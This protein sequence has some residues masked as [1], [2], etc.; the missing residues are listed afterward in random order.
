MPS[1]QGNVYKQPK[2]VVIQQTT[3]PTHKDQALR[4]GP[5]QRTTRFAPLVK[6]GRQD[7]NPY[8]PSYFEHPQNVAMEW[9]KLQSLPKGSQPPDWLDVDKLNE[10]YEYLKFANGN[11]PWTE[12]KYLNPKDDLGRGLLQ[13]M[14]T[15][16]AATMSPQYAAMYSN[17]DSVMGGE[18]NW[19]D[20][21]PDVRK[22]VLADPKFDIAMFPAESRGQI[23][24]DSNFDWSRL[25]AWQKPYYI[26]SSSPLLAGGTQAA[27]IGLATVGPAGVVGGFAVGSGLGWAAGKV[28]YDPVKEFW[29][30]GNIGSGGFGLLQFLGEQPEKLLGFLVQLYGKAVGVPGAGA[31]E[32]ILTWNAW[33]AGASLSETLIPTASGISS[34]F[35]KTPGRLLQG[36][37]LVEAYS[38]MIEAF[39]NPKSTMLGRTEK[40]EIGR[41]DF[42]TAT[43]NARK[44][45]EAGAN[46]REVMYR[47][48]DTVGAQVGDML[49]QAVTDPLNVVPGI[50]KNITAKVL[51]VTGHPTAAAAMS[52]SRGIV[53]GIK[54]YG[55]KVRA[56]AV[57]PNFKYSEMTGLQR[58]LAG[59]TLG[60]DG[61]PVERA[62][63]FTKAPL[64]SA[65]V[66]K[67][68]T[69]G[70]G[71]AR[72]WLDYMTT[73][74]PFARA[75]EGL[76]MVSENMLNI[77]NMFESPE[78][79]HAFWTKLRSGDYSQAREMSAR[80]T[81]APEMYTSLVAIKNYTMDGALTLWKLSR[82]NAT[83]VERIAFVL[84][85]TGQD[86][87]KDISTPAKA[88]QTFE[89]LR[90]AI[91]TLNDPAANILKTEIA[92][93]TFTVDDLIQAGK[94]FNGPSKA[95]LDFRQWKAMTGYEVNTHFENWAKDFFH[96]APD[97]KFFRAAH[98]LKTAQSLLL[99]GINPK[100]AVNNI[101]N[102]MV[103]RVATGNFGYMTPKQ[104]AA[105][106]DDL[107]IMPYRLEEGVG[108]AGEPHQRGESGNII[109]QALR[110]QKGSIAWMD[111]ALRSTADK[112][113]LA[114][115]FSAW[116]EKV[117]G[118]NAFVIGIK[119]MY[120]QLWRV[121][122]G[123][124]RMDRG[125][126]AAINKVY[127][128]GSDLMY[129]AIEAG[130]NKAHIEKIIS[131]SI[132]NGMKEI[133][134][135]G[136]VNSVARSQGIDPAQSATMLDEMG[137]LS[138]LD[139][140]L[141]GVTSEAGISAAFNRAAKKAQD[142]IDI[143]L[144]NEFKTRVE[145]VTNKITH[146]GWAAVHDTYID[147]TMRYHEDWRKGF[148]KLNDA[149]NQ[150][151]MIDD[152]VLRGTLLENTYK[153]LMRDWQRTN[154]FDL[155]SYK[156][157]AEAMGMGKI[158]VALDFLSHKAR[159]ADLWNEAFQFR[160]DESTRHTDKY[161]TD[162]DNPARWDDWDLTQ[163]RIH[164]K[165]EDTFQ[166]V[167]LEEAEMGALFSD[168]FKQR[169]GD[170]IGALAAQYW[171][172]ISDFREKMWT[173]QQN[174]RAKQRILTAEQRKAAAAKF[175]H[176]RYPELITE[177][178]HMKI[179]GSLR[180]DEAL[181]GRVPATQTEMPG[182]PPAK[183][184][185]PEPI[186]PRPAVDPAVYKAAMDTEYP[187]TSA[188]P[189][190]S[191]DPAADAHLLAIV[192]RYGGDVGKNVTSMGEVTPD[193]M[194]KAMLD[195][196]AEKKLQL[197]FPKVEEEP[198]LTP[199]LQNVQDA[200]LDPLPTEKVEF[201]SE[202]ERLLAIRQEELDKHLEV[203][204]SKSIKNIKPEIRDAMIPVLQEMAKEAIGT[205]QSLLQFI[206]KAGGL[207]YEK[208]SKR[209]FI[210]DVTGEPNPKKDWLPGLFG[211]KGHVLD[212]MA[213]MLEE[214]GFLT[215]SDIADPMDNG[216]V[217][218]VTAMIQDELAGKKHFRLFDDTDMVDTTPDW[219]KNIN[220]GKNKRSSIQRMIRQILAGEDR[221]ADG[222]EALAAEKAIKAE[223]FNRAVFANDS[224]LMR[225][226]GLEVKYDYDGWKSRI[227][228]I[229]S[230]VPDASDPVLMRDRIVSEGGLMDEIMEASSDLP[231][232]APEEYSQYYADALN[233]IADMG[234]QATKLANEQAKKGKDTF[235]VAKSAAEAD[236]IEIQAEAHADALMTRDVYKE[237]LIEKFGMSE[238]QA[239]DQVGIIQARAETWAKHTGK[240]ADQFWQEKIGH[241]VRGG[242]DA[243]LYQ[244]G[245]QPINRRMTPE[246]TG[247]YARALV[248][249]GADELRR[250]VQNEASPADR[251]AILDAAHGIDAK[252][253]ETVALQTQSLFQGKKGAISWTDEGRA[254][255]HALE[256][257][258]F[259]TVTHEIGHLFVQELR[260]TAI[261]A[262]P[263][264]KPQ[265]EADLRTLEDWAG[266]KAGED[267]SVDAH[268]KLARGYEQYIAEGKAPTPA[269]VAVFKRMKEWM[270]AIYKAIVG[271]QIDVNLSDD[272][273]RVFDRL[274]GQE[275]EAPVVR[276][277]AKPL[278][279]EAQVFAKMDEIMGVPK[280]EVAT[281]QRYSDNPK[282]K[283]YEML[284]ADAIKQMFDQDVSRAVRNADGWKKSLAE[285]NETPKRPKS[286]RDKAEWNITW[287]EKVSK[288]TEPSE[289]QLSGYRNKYIKSVKENI[290][291][292]AS[293]PEEVIRQRPE[294]RKAMDARARYE[295]GLHTSFANQ[296]AGVDSTMKM[297]MGYKVKRQDG[298]EI[299]ANQIAEIRAQVEDVESVLGTMKDIF[300]NSDI[301]IAHTNGKH[302]FLSKAGGMYHPGDKTITVGIGDIKAFAH[303]WAHWMDHEAGAR[304]R[305]EA[306]VQLSGRNKDTISALSETRP[307]LI[308]MAKRKINDVWEVSKIM[309]ADLSKA[310]PEEKVV[311]ESIKYKLGPYWKE[312]REIWARLVEQ[313][314]GEKGSGIS[315]DKDL[316]NTPGWWKQED[317][318]ALKPMIKEELDRRLAILRGGAEAE[319]NRVVF[320]KNNDVSYI[321][322]KGFSADRQYIYIRKGDDGKW[323][324]YNQHY[325]KT[326]VRGWVEDV[327]VDN[328]PS[329]EAAKIE[330][331]KYLGQ[332]KIV[333]E[334]PPVVAIEIT[335]PVAQEP[336][337]LGE[338]PPL[339]ATPRPITVGDEVHLPAEN[340]NAMVV[341][342][343]PDGRL[344]LDNGRVESSA[345]VDLIAAQE[346]MFG[347][348]GEKAP[349]KAPPTLF[350]EADPR[351][352]SGD[353]DRASQTLFEGE[354]LRDAWST[355]VEPLLSGMEQEA[356]KQFRAPKFDS[357][358]LDAQTQAS[359]TKYL[360]Q[361]KGEMA[362]SKLASVRYGEGMRDF[363]MLNYNRRYGFDKYLDVVAPYQF[364]YTRTM[365]NWGMRA[366]DRPAFFSNYARLNMM[367]NR[368][369]NDLPE[370]FR[371]KYSIHAPWLPDWMGDEIFI[372]P[373][374]SIFPFANMLTPFET[375]ARDNNYQMIETE[376]ILQEWAQDE[377]YS[378]TDIANAAS[379]RTGSIWEKAVAEAKIRRQSDISNPM[380]FMAALLGPAWY[381]SMPAKALGLEIPYINP[382]G[383]G[384][385]T[386]GNLPITSTARAAA[387]VTRGTWAEPFGQ[388]VGLLGKPE[389]WVRKQTGMPEFGEYGDYYVKRQIANMVVDGLISVEQAEQAMLERKGEIYDQARE[390]V[391]MELAMRI[392]GA[393]GTYAALNEGLAAGASAMLPSLLGGQILP[394]GELEYRGQAPE[395]YQ[396]LK[397]ADQLFEDLGGDQ[398]AIDDHIK[399]HPGDDFIT[400]FFNKYPEYE[401]YLAKG[402]DEKTLLRN[403][404]IGQ[405]W[406][407]YMELS[408]EDQRIIKAQMPDIF[409]RSFMDKET[410]SYDSID[411]PTLAMWAKVFKGMVPETV[412]TKEV[413]DTPQYQ[414]P[415]ILGMPAPLQQAMDDY[416]LAK[417]QTFPGINDIQSIYFAVPENRRRKVLQFYPQL[418][419]YW[420]WR[421][422]YLGKHP[423][424]AQFMDDEFNTAILNNEASPVGMDAA[425][426]QR[427]LKYYKSDFIG[428]PVRTYDSYFADVSPT[429]KTQFTGFVLK[430]T[431]MGTGAYKELRLIWEQAG[432][433]MGNMELWI[434]RVLIPTMP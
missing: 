314:V 203:I 132:G 39:L 321:A 75:R 291:H 264:Y 421:R 381:L 399:E 117:E 9:N 1:K 370:R 190:G 289:A 348:I 252:M 429:L 382:Q 315:A 166:A 222:M 237:Q 419:D 397:M 340:V 89:T 17:I 76:K 99:L 143:R 116:S 70:L 251:V 398:Q 95:P 29:Q 211:K 184:V 87:V 415:D 322:Q 134:A 172:E 433:P 317:F 38:P 427:I 298:K 106:I 274:L 57:D 54:T 100:Y 332:K 366:L 150:L 384:A 152:P 137:V 229:V 161:R 153:E 178:E 176:E 305:F 104:I 261:D 126:E 157:M 299:P 240:S 101:I 339:P 10:A 205:K 407:N 425:A 122:K 356:I 2:P 277:P 342:I 219:Y 283:P 186:E 230:R 160:I 170:E 27:A 343:L 125:L 120:N 64:L 262:L 183:P 200:T 90:T 244:E 88:T 323:I 341:E 180:I 369:A 110:E 71:R 85:R 281:L 131:E 142:Q 354:M 82:D 411:T 129:R 26:A 389:E 79:I 300:E 272:V 81:E 103:S 67:E 327:V 74:Q 353:Y 115:K 12:W 51:D 409:K 374:R 53:E 396:A 345:N 173:E 309:K 246:E 410:R 158:P 414:M 393:A 86:I 196:A 123:F 278:A 216:G 347:A 141:K 337:E 6:Q 45:I 52:G 36:Q 181:R 185:T 313:Y 379:T 268:E 193:L 135:K 360:N 265:I 295:K 83:V 359:L 312:P 279:T 215:M 266:V 225:A 376:R 226:L 403:F 234:E 418:A 199:E 377:T 43:I 387:A 66:A 212:Q 28:G 307:D 242:E 124:T 207:Y 311:I 400:N 318:D 128:G 270:L 386:I 350:Q 331:E 175:W 25:P 406:D 192:R 198:T 49:F 324:M 267:W 102:N 404:L 168:Q 177:L 139:A 94:I 287:W 426:A 388:L 330:A 92:A 151:D 346:N 293:V 162:W 77:M 16:P 235:A 19:S 98:M 208:G 432:K 249:A 169:H 165:F 285:M 140:N 206:Q 256:S 288:Q 61:M 378:Q 239:A 109:T 145:H 121:D 78:E 65:Q 380:D 417:R 334:Q 245:L 33:N 253:A 269:L 171:Q 335:E 372:D 430:G 156:G 187:V 107:G 3:G 420:D 282:A 40:W 31:I 424:V 127:P 358:K 326:A 35:W 351:T 223:A 24:A 22:S 91:D 383:G 18:A 355:L 119:R 241:I 148:D 333:V 11:T 284:E 167:A 325:D 179:G 217:N 118:A 130:M 250:A 301:T 367:Q 197:E 202:A 405:I 304:V 338:A 133:Y 247:N 263:E 218:K 13:S 290:S 391:E 56:G 257:P 164:K 72:W 44:E 236:A 96:L 93:G 147:V 155:S 23:M 233:K 32:D 97:S 320:V 232:D 365:L 243:A 5:W 63:K 271:S 194:K 30:Q 195:R 50:S 286:Q 395:W 394:A 154:A 296:S 7:P 310:T 329:L 349:P 191:I 392:P 4:K 188:K 357:S 402:K 375:M 408:K 412:E 163:D 316:T 302:P 46:Y 204:Q 213:I 69:S 62:G 189:D 390:R 42:I 73:L 112:I 15:P 276:E 238:E 385:E 214:E 136:L 431:A 328:I 292:G 422:A 344:R 138:E 336:L 303:E 306:N 308:Q 294:F 209:N 37:G 363:A 84:K 182:T 416:N 59:L 14:G 220:A 58:T 144:G 149:F 434:K 105:F 47:Y 259:T 319:A 55:S 60:E 258:D 8:K 227:D 48:Q 401:A 248:R 273:R 201:V 275:A 362:T 174:F 210:R 373:K 159:S 21:A 114:S 368:Y 371:G 108:M 224:E 364:W 423:E 352:Q 413:I 41:G 428:D 297:E 111:N 34:E 146:E 361:K 20:L 280:K 113:G 228:D 80:V 254:I 231:V 221:A 68:T 255:L 260:Q